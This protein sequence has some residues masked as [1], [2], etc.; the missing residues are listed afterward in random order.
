[1]VTIKTEQTAIQA[2]LVLSQ[3]A[4]TALQQLAVAAVFVAVRRQALQHLAQDQTVIQQAAA[5][6]LL[7]Q[8]AMHM[9]SPAALAASLYLPFTTPFQETLRLMGRRLALP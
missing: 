8:L 7:Q 2:S 3:G 1:M 6:A 9:V 5:V 4:H